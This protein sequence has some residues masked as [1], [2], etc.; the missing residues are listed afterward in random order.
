MSCMTIEEHLYW[1]DYYLSREN[2]TVK[3]QEYYYN[4]FLP[5]YAK[6]PKVVILVLKKIERRKED[7]SSPW[8]L[9]WSAL[10]ASH[11]MALYRILSRQDILELEAGGSTSTKR[12]EK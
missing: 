3:T 10:T 8:T 2:G 7:F 12:K 4:E 11:F 5:W 9:D 1:L 6:T